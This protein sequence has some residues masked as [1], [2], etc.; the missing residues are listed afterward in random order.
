VDEEIDEMRNMG[1][2]ERSEAAYESPLVLVKK[3]DGTYRVCEFQR[4]E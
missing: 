4:A 1:I 2:I 3:S